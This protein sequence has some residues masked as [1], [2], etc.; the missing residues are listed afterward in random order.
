MLLNAGQKCEKR[1]FER[2]STIPSRVRAQFLYRI[3]DNT[4]SE[5]ALSLNQLERI[6]KSTNFGE[7]IHN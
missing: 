1:L 6:E 2:Q 7:M 5:I 3:F 4:S